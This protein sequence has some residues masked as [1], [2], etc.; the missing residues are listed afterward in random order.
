[1]PGWKPSEYARTVGKSGEALALP[2][3]RRLQMTRL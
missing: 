2:M 3:L 1:M